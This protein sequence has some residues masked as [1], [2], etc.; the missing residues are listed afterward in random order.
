MK[1]VDIRESNLNISQDEFSESKFLHLQNEFRQQ[2]PNTLFAIEQLWKKIVKNANN[3]DD[4]IKI[5]HL[6]LHLADTCGT[7]GADEVSYIARKCY[8]TFKS[9]EGKDFPV[10]TNTKII[11]SLNDKLAR[12]NILSHEWLSVEAPVFLKTKNKVNRTEKTVYSLMYDNVSLSELT[13]QAEKHNCNIVQ[14]DSLNKIITACASKNPIS[15]IV[16]S[17]FIDGDISGICAVEHLKEHLSDCPPIIF[18]SDKNDAD[19]RL[20]TAQAGVD[21]YFCR[22]LKVNK[23]IH[24]LKGFNLELDN[25]PYRVMIIDNDLPLL[26]CYS[27]V[28]SESGMVVSSV[29]NPFDGFNSIE[30]FLP[31]IIVLDMYMPECSGKELVNMIRQD[32]RWALMPII[33]LSGEQDIQ[34]QLEAIDLGAD[35]FLVKPVN[36]NKLVS[37]VNASAKRARNN[38]K[39]NRELK[40]TLRENESQLIALDEHAIVSVADVYGRIIHVN[41]KLCEIS[42]YSRDELLDQNHNILKSGYHDKSFYKN[43]WDTISRGEIWHGVICNK[44]KSGG[45]YWVDS[46]IVP[47][48]DD[49]GKPYKYVSVRTDVTMLRAS[50]DRLSRSQEFANIGTWDW[51]ISSNEL[52]WSDQMWPL[53]GF[54]KKNVNP[55]YEN[56]IDAIHPDD[57]ELVTNAIRDCSENGK[58]YNIEHRIVWPDGSIHWLHESGNMVRNTNEAPVNMLGVVRDITEFKTTEQKMMLAREEA[59]KANL[60]KSKF[61]SSMSHELRTP[62]NSIVGFSQLLQMSKTQPLTELQENNVGEIMV[63]GN[64]LMNL[65]DDVLDLSKI[66]A[67]HIELSQSNVDINSI[68]KESIQLIMPLAQSRGI[69]IAIICN[70]KSIEHSQLEKDNY[71]AHTDKTRFKQ[72]ILNLLSNATKYNREGGK[73]TL[74]YNKIE[75]GRLKLTVTDTGEGLTFEQQDQL[76][77]AFNRL[78]LEKTD[79]EGSG[80]G[81]VI[82]KKIVE[83]MGGKIGVISKVGE[84]STFWV[85]LPINSDE[86]VETIKNKS[87]TKSTD[88]SNVKQNNE[89]K[90]VLYIEDNPANLRLVEQVLEC[91][92]YIKMWSAPE[93]L[94]GLELAGEHIPDLILLDINLP[95]M[96]GYQVL[97]KLRKQESTKDIPVIAI[98]AN[99]MPK[100][101][102]KGKE[103]GFDG[104]ITKPINIKELLEEVQGKLENVG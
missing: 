64:H 91:I 31:D 22:P 19:Y 76:F 3:A 101:I 89:K 75:D 103:A 58:T 30:K 16:D 60:E 85:E 29:S 17:D 38:I 12:L 23:V 97:K 35:D 104:Y 21:R 39:L 73:I 67:G 90:S 7:Y 102:N 72:I 6:L 50:E 10:S 94:L 98:S 37:V 57:R 59:E 33:F 9:F 62:M 20:K 83:L 93:P 70:D 15:I 24:T 5:S 2:L 77:T 1:N 65:I 49:T 80:I 92:P 63:A 96:D 68:V 86:P 41:D 56:F 99:A 74:A 36:T 44:T 28:L 14:F 11:E 54:D 45:E 81:L 55:T 32:D 8:L 25:I 51:N 43:L 47:F 100:D 26:E 71:F 66:E 53:F 42:G 18:I 87:K 61:L 69:E 78:G 95:G 40:A 4:S 79:V 48:L 13:Q 27:T 88:K 34:N 52:Y 82:T 46:T 84:G